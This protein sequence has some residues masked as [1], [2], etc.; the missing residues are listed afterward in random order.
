M[1]AARD[2]VR[3]G[4]AALVRADPG[5]AMT[6]FE[7][8]E[9]RA[10][11][12]SLRLS[13]PPMRVLG[14]LPVVRQQIATARALASASELVARAGRA[15]AV[16]ATELDGGV[17]AVAPTDGGFPVEALSS[18]RPQLTRAA[19]LATRARDEVAATESRFLAPPL[20]EGRNLLLTEL[21]PAVRSLT[22]AAALADALPTFLGAD[23]PRRYLFGAATPAEL[24]GTGGLIGAYAQMT[25][26]DGRVSF[27]DFVPASALPRAVDSP[28]PPPSE[29]YQRRYGEFNASG[30]WSN[31]NMTPDFPTA[32]V[33]IERLHAQTT[34]EQVDGTV[35]ADPFALQLLL[36]ATGPVEVPGVGAVRADTVV[37]YLTHDSYV[38]LPD[39]D[40]RKSVLGRVAVTVFE[41]FLRSETAPAR[42]GELLAQAVREGHVLLHARDADVQAAFERAEVA[43]QL[44]PSAGDY[45]AVIANNAGGNKLDSFAE[46][47]LDYRVDLRADGTARGRLQISIANTAPAKGLP[48]YVIGP[49]DER[50]DPGE[51]VML[52][53]TFCSAWCH[54]D[55]FRVDGEPTPITQQ[56]EL[57]RQVLASTVRV[58]A[59]ETRELAYAW[60]LL[61]GWS[62]TE[63]GGAYQ[64]TLQGQPTVRPTP[65]SLRVRVPEQMEVTR[66]TGGAHVAGDEV[67]WSGT[68]DRVVRLEVE[69][70]PAGSAWQR[71]RAFLNRPWF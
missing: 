22:A 60:K 25:T 70:S 8:A 28:P 5:M 11:A 67:S 14:V 56:P 62:A 48:R 17:A 71:V 18:L 30:H 36:E 2:D 21:E 20:R 4:A 34:G 64:L 27:H 58:A 19:G 39:P 63:S 51:N 61:R 15:V 23:G 44:L 66:A 50:F 69:F 40:N 32:A 54:S 47:S 16:G 68:L 52:L 13:S 6:A 38:E 7:R 42:K 55:G 65:V 33:A 12:A 41:E 59:G 29:D 31:I 9:G 43:G 10:E 1:A 57:G 53:S 45:V 37:D 49:S 3:G 24:R 46:R 35:V 26:Q